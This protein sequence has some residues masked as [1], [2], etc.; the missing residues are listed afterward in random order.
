MGLIGSRF[1]A[2]EKGDHSNEDVVLPTSTE[3]NVGTPARSSSKAERPPTSLLF[4]AI[5]GLK[6]DEQK[7]AQMT[8]AINSAASIVDQLVAAIQNPRP[9]PHTHQPGSQEG[10]QVF[11]AT[12]R[13]Q[14]QKDGSDGFGGNQISDQTSDLTYGQQ[15]VVVATGLHAHGNAPGPQRWKELGDTDF[16]QGIVEQA[17]ALGISKVLLFLHGYN[18]SHEAALSSLARLAVALQS[19][20][21]HGKVIPVAFDWASAAMLDKY[22]QLVRPLDAMVTGDREKVEQGAARFGKPLKHLM[23]ACEENNL[24]LHIL[25]HSMGNYA[26]SQILSAA[27]DSNNVVDLKFSCVQSVTLAAADATREEISSI[28]TAAYL[29]N[30]RITLL[31]WPDNNPLTSLLLTAL[32]GVP[33]LNGARGCLMS[34]ELQRLKVL[35]LMHTNSTCES[36]LTGLTG[37]EALSLSGADYTFD[38]NDPWNGVD[39]QNLCAMRSLRVLDLQDAEISAR[40]KP[41][42][43]NLFKLRMLVLSAHTKDQLS[44]MLQSQ[45][46]PW[47]LLDHMAILYP[48]N[49]KLQDAKVPRTWWS[50]G[51]LHMYL[52]AKRAGSLEQ[53][54]IDEER[55]RLFCSFWHAHSEMM[56]DDYTDYTTDKERDSEEEEPQ[57]E[58]DSDED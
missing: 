16:Y 4:E 54:A 53:D 25:A 7:C 39:L 24:E 18:T 1:Q 52:N 9:P 3:S 37:L 19:G 50:N 42:Q 14:E 46:L 22:S 36:V 12:D 21:L 30:A 27:R 34:G 8:V 49:A 55:I 15:D 13:A 51:Y 47:R 5:E 17:K 56:P 26:I 2:S 35:A 23:A 32:H 28:A 57:V 20:L 48:G 10:T 41:E 40:I 45:W 31:S 33:S 44:G 29:H 43:I 58:S 11:F 38:D 6:T